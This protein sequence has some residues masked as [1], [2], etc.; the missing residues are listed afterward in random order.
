MT[1]KRKGKGGR[2][3]PKNTRPRNWNDGTASPSHLSLVPEMPPGLDE[4]LPTF[5][6]AFAVI[7]DAQA[8]S[9]VSIFASESQRPQAITRVD[10]EE[11]A[12]NRVP[13][14]ED[15]LEILSEF[16]TRPPQRIV[17]AVAVF[18]TYGNSSS[19][20]ARHILRSFTN[21]PSKRMDTIGKA[22]VTSALCIEDIFGE[23]IQY[24]LD[25]R[26]PDGTEGVIAILVDRLMGNIVKD[27]M[28]LP[29]IASFTDAIDDTPELSY[30]PVPIG[31]V[32]AAS[33]DAFAINDMTIEIETVVSEAVVGLR[34]MLETILTDHMRG[35]LP[36][37]SIEAASRSSLT[38][39]FSL[40]ARN[41]NPSIADDL[42]SWA[43]LPIDFAFDYGHGDPTRW[44]PNAS[45]AFLDWSTRK[46]MASKDELLQI[47]E[48]MRVFVPWAHE[49]A[50]WGTTYL[51]QV[52]QAI[53]D[54]IPLFE[55]SIAD[56]GS[57][58]LSQQVLREALDGIDLTDPDAID[59]AMNAYNAGL[60]LA[61]G[62]T[63]PPQGGSHPEAFDNSGPAIGSERVASVAEIASV[64]A[65]AIFD[66]EYV[67]LVRRLTADAARAKPGLFARGKVDIWASGVIYAIAQLNGLFS[68]WGAMAVSAEH[69]TGRLAG[70][71][72]TISSK[73][74]S[75]REAIGEG[76]WS[77]NPRYQHGSSGY[78]PSWLNLADTGGDIYDRFGEGSIDDYVPPD[79][80]RI[81][82]RLGATS[83]FTL[84]CQLDELPAWRVI[85][86]P[87]SST[88]S[89]LHSTLQVVFEWVGYHLH[90]FEVGSQR[91]TTDP[92]PD[93]VVEG[94]EECDDTKIRLDE[95]VRP[96]QALIYTYDFGDN[97]VVRIEV[98]ELSETGRR[99]PRSELLDGEGDAPPEDC[100]GV[101]GFRQLV[102]ILNN[103]AD[104]EYEQMATWA[105][106][107]RP[108]SFDLAV[109]QKRL[110]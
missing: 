83:T 46:V 40:W 107:Y 38:E 4:L 96:G 75:V 86:V 71:S 16:G 72:G 50:G 13:S 54:F 43:S 66:D 74:C 88:L 19:S 109:I 60:E 73:A 65:R 12:G 3:T 70:A 2:T 59:A 36:E 30:W 81:H 8:A 64:A 42:L 35:S 22:T 104:P 67:T 49:K 77:S 68:G 87:A 9:F 24:A 98:S 23:A 52:L 47:P 55:A 103:P 34:P 37:E 62:G 57:Q 85:R 79:P 97:W 99:K 21:K 105:G 48:M 20:Q 92:D 58:S 1:R 100:G 63:I 69:L 11:R 7:R 95:L 110:I 31:E 94:D 33:E 29:D 17:D 53:E 61:H 6:D 108:G 5:D 102:E 39:E 14:A 93:F 44:G 56:P 18:V 28:V 80:V 106:E 76:L 82:E 90:M 45:I 32:K 89:E 26:Y 101:W 78:D 84:R 51:D 91:F 41:K 15:F 27:I 25:L 10:E